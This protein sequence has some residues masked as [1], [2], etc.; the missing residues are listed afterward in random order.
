MAIE[1]LFNK[2][3]QKKPGKLTLPQKVFPE[4]V[5]P[6]AAIRAAN[7][8]SEAQLNPNITIEH[9]LV[10]LSEGV[11]LQ[12]ILMQGLYEEASIEAVTKRLQIAILAAHIVGVLQ[13][14]AMLHEKGVAEDVIQEILAE[15]QGD[16]SG[17]E[18]V[19]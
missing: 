14:L 6:A 2:K 9:V 18:K 5:K 7:A 16:V 4:T 8:L 11:G 1:D 17:G 19:V 13:T 12:E 3:E 15:L 10:E